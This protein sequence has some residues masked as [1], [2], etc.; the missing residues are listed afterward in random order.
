MCIFHICVFV[1]SISDFDRF[2][3]H[4]T[5]QETLCL[6]TQ[7]TGGVCGGLPVGHGCAEALKLRCFKSNDMISFGIKSSAT[8][9]LGTY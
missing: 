5:C 2:L 4:Q 7:G 6:W 1:D 8:E 9:A 3:W